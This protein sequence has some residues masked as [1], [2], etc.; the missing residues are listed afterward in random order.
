MRLVIDGCA[1]AT[2]DG[3]RTEHAVGHVVVDGARVES[4]A[5]GRAPRGLPDATYVDGTG[6]LATPGFVNTHHH[7]YQWLTRG[8]AVD[9]TLF[10]WL[11]TLYPCL[12]YTSPSPRDS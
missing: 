1:V 8:A 6:C 4:V 5:E 12:L 10:D 3:D 7:L 9:D 11:A 2:M